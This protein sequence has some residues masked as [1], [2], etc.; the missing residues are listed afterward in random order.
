MRSVAVCLLGVCALP[1]QEDPATLARQALAAR[2]AGQIERSIELYRKALAT[3]PD[4]PESWWYLGLNYYDRDRHAE[5]SGAFSEVAKQAPDNGPA[6]A[7]LGLC[8]FEEKK[9]ETALAHIVLGKQKGIP[10]GSELDRVAHYHYLVLANKIGQFELA[11][12]LLAEVAA[13]PVESVPDLV[14]LAGL[15]ALRMPLLPAEIHG[16]TKDAVTIAGRASVFAWTN[17]L[18]Q[19][20][21]D[22]DVLL[23]KYPRLPN[24][25]YLRGYILLL[26]HDPACIDEF[27]NE[28][29]VSPRH[30]QARLRIAYEY[31]QRGDAD[32]GLPFAEQ[33]V[34]LAPADFMAHNFLGRILL[35]LDKTAIALAHLQTAVK[36]A[37]A[38]PDAH[39]HLAAALS[40]AGRAKEAARHREIF[41][42]LEEARRAQRATTLPSQTAR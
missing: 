23:A 3:R 30:V 21:A 34:Q 42:K 2:Q 9:Y 15:S 27:R 40:R 32:K 37:P 20:L 38:S 24:A 25:H 18:D 22:A 39:F 19:A 8:E 29:E 28:L 6:F 12:S 35:D 33:A 4:D 1:A 17:Q 13:K 7:F 16:E 36:L 11:G 41:K 10:P 26:R 14:E 31:L 5:C